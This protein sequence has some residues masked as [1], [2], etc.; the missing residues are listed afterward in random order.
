MVDLVPSTDGAMLPFSLATADPTQTARLNDALFAVENLAPDRIDAT[1][2]PAVLAF[3]YEGADGLRVR[4]QFALR[5]D[6]LRDFPRR[7]K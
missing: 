5:A 3:V 4:K 1:A 6:G 2:T 7:R